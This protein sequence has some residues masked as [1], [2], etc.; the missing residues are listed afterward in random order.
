MAG[1][2]MT[3]PLPLAGPASLPPA[4]SRGDR[5]AAHDPIPLRRVLHEEA[6]GRDVHPAEYE[7]VRRW[8]STVLHGGEAGDGAPRA[9]QRHALR[10]RRSTVLRP[11]EH[12]SPALLL[13]GGQPQEGEGAARSAVRHPVP[14]RTVQPARDPAVRLLREPVARDPGGEPRAH[15]E[16]VFLL[17]GSALPRHLGG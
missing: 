2:A 15:S 13:P 7:A 3:R 5:A 14:V 6:A 11:S 9:G 17:R 16:M 1:D 4:R 8:Q 12:P 10:H